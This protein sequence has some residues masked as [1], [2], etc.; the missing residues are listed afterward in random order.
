MPH[1]IDLLGHNLNGH[2]DDHILA[3]GI[4]VI[5][6]YIFISVEIRFNFSFYFAFYFEFSINLFCL[7]CFVWWK[8]YNWNHEQI[9][10]DLLN[11]PPLSGYILKLLFLLISCNF[12]QIFILQLSIVLIVLIGCNA[13]QQTN[14]DR[15]WVVVCLIWK[16]MTRKILN[17][18]DY[19][20][21]LW[22]F[23]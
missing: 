5:C 22:F 13:V 7:F 1:L 19:L 10:Q 3:L 20:I 9:I 6:H 17:I 15:V 2:S 14:W 4:Q 16:W 21:L 11:N 12:F 23:F 8:Q 18:C